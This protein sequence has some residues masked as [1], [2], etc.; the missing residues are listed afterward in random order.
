MAAAQA[1]EAAGRERAAVQE[2]VAQQAAA[3][4]GRT[5]AAG[6]VAEREIF[7]TCHAQ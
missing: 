6:L 7:W 4:T 2:L 5:E 1:T 3:A